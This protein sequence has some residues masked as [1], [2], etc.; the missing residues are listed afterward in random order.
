MSIFP[1]L[2]SFVCTMII[3]YFNQ[4]IFF[5]I[6]FALI[7]LLYI[8]IVMFFNNFMTYFSF[9]ALAKFDLVS[10]NKK[11]VLKIKEVINKNRKVIHIYNVLRKDYILLTLKNAHLTLL[12]AS[13]T[14]NKEL[15]ERTIKDL[16]TIGITKS[17]IDKYNNLPNLISLIES[18]KIEIIIH[19]EKDGNKISFKEISS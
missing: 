4:D 8:S 1:M 2:L 5:T 16:E 6:N 9:E 14:K 3:I 15:F 13:L 12:T 7:L 17:I 19:E 18:K 11:L 10:K